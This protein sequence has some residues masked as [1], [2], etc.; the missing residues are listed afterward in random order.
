MPGYIL[1]V[2]RRFQRPLPARPELAPHKYAPQNFKT[3]GPTA[4]IPDDE[5][6]PLSHSGITRTQRII[7]CL[8]YY[9]RAID[10]PILP[11]ISDIGS[12]QIKATESTAEAVVKLLNY[13]ATFPDAVVKYIVEDMCLWIDSESSYLSIQ[14]SRSRAG[15]FFYI[16][17]HP[18]KVPKNKDPRP[19]GPIH[20]LCKTMKM[21]V[22]SAAE[23][24]LGGLF[25]N[26]Q[27]DIPLRTTLIKLG[28]QQPK[29]GTPLKTD[30]ITA[31]GIVHNNVRQHK[32][33]A[34][35][36]HLYWIRDRVKQGHYNVYW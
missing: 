6:P 8:L 22:A 21:V 17:D 35:D 33:R 13:C 16:S 5:T 30:N 4:P 26:R 9:E 1:G 23:A 11:S 25:F 24:E 19:N 31:D 3:S 36:M 29:T 2:I 14:K 28:H 7:G 10:G 32:S 27:E 12:E 15:G 34:M 20:I 18:S